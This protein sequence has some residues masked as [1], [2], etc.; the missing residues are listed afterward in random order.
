MKRKSVAPLISAWV[1]FPCKIN[2]PSGLA[3]DLT[4]YYQS[5]LELIAF[6]Q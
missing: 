6:Y 2:K 1:F 5:I 3:G 4:D